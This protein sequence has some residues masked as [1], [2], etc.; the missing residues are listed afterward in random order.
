MLLGADSTRGINSIAQFFTVLLIFVGVLALT[1][2]TT[3]WVATYQKGKMLSSNINVIE[4]LKI[5]ANKYIQIVKIG[6]KY[7]AVAIGKD[8]IHLIGEISEESLK[9]PETQNMNAPG[10]KE[11]LENAKNFKLK[12]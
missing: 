10:F 1:Y 4:T 12:K 8:E 7:F 9:I 6:D 3:R 11:I 2:F 5:T